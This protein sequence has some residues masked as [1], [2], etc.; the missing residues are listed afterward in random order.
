MTQG[1]T[2][3]NRPYE[4]GYSDDEVCKSF[5]DDLQSLTDKEW[6]M[7]DSMKEQQ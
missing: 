6:K 2:T 3:E 1:N 7:L 4:I 5:M